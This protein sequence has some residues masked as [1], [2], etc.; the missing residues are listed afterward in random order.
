MFPGR[1]IG[2]SAGADMAKFDPKIESDGFGTGF[3]FKEFLFWGG[4]G[5][6]VEN[7]SLGSD[8]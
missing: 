5:W 7:G 3:Q 8:R 6:R 1:T 4:K 2:G